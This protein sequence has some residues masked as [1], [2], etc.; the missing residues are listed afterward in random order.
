MSDLPIVL[1]CDDECVDR[2]TEH[3]VLIPTVTAEESSLKPIVDASSMVVDLVKATILDKKSWDAVGAPKEA[4][5]FK[6]HVR[7]S[8]RVGITKSTPVTHD[9]S[10]AWLLLSMVAEE[11][12]PWCSG[13]VPR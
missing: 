2:G 11:R 1:R 7:S 5:R 13:G 4:S 8:G 10:I 12:P 9:A 3:L 6:L